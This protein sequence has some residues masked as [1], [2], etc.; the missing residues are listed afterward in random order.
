MEFPSNGTDINNSNFDSELYLSQVLSQ[1]SLSQVRINRFHLQGG[2]EKRHKG[3]VET[4]R[5]NRD[6]G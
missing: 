5:V 2:L 3:W 4:P 1:R 6:T